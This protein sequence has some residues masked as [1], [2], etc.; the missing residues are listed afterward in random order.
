M[1]SFSRFNHNAMAAASG[2]PVLPPV[3]VS[4]RLP[5]KR[6][7]V[8]RQLALI[9]LAVFAASFVLGMLV[10]ML[11]AHAVEFWHAWGWFGYPG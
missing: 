9:S 3:P 6:R 5:A 7:R 2:R 8:L 11:C 1:R 4:P 10:S